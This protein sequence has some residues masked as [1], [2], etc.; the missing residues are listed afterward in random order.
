MGS[1]ALSSAYAMYQHEL[2]VSSLLRLQIEDEKNYYFIIAYFLFWSKKKSRFFFSACVKKKQMN[3]GH[4]NLVIFFR[5]HRT[6]E[7]L[8]HVA[9]RSNPS[10]F[11]QLDCVRWPKKI[12]FDWWLHWIRTFLR[13]GF[14]YFGFVNQI[15]FSCHFF[16]LN[17]FQDL[18]FL[19]TQNFWPE[20][21]FNPTCCLKWE[22]H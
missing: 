19:L 7:K 4:L 2:C 11:G 9:P 8:Q 10:G 22:T 20:S 3:R 12:A 1:I 21:R 16:Y 18:F 15:F 17:F 13:C 6:I 14:V 5:L